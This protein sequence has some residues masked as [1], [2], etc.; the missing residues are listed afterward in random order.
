MFYWYHASED[1][2]CPGYETTLSEGADL[3]TALNTT[4]AGAGAGA[5]GEGGELRPC[6][7]P[8]FLGT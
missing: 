4:A 5:G 7:S 2:G 6:L 3:A 8:E 1:N